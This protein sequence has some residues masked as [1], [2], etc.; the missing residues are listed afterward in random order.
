[1]FRRFSRTLATAPSL[2]SISLRQSVTGLTL[3]AMVHLLGNGTP[4]RAGPLAFSHSA[5][6]CV[7]NLSMANSIITRPSVFGT[8]PDSAA[9]IHRNQTWQVKDGRQH[10]FQ[11]CVHSAPSACDAQ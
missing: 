5:R 1:M 3:T 11:G 9:S 7:Y 10:L 4:T 8:A 6:L 2:F